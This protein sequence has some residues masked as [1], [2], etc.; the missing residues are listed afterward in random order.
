MADE[1]EFLLDEVFNWD[2]GY[3]LPAGC[4]NDLLLATSDV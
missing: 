4:D 2:W 1:W 3:L